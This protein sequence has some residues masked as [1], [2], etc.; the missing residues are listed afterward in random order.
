[1]AQMYASA[2]GSKDGT[3][4]GARTWEQESVRHAGDNCDEVSLLR[5]EKHLSQG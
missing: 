1:M 3:R 5:V 2:V 4:A